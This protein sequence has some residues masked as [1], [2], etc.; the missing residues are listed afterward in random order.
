MRQRRNGEADTI[1]ERNRTLQRN[2][3]NKVSTS[4]Q[5]DDSTT[6]KKLKGETY[7]MKN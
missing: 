6:H 7:V 3:S 4:G 5:L 2:I 1:R